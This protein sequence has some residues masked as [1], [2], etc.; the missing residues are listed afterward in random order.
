MFPHFINLLKTKVAFNLK[1]EAGKSQLSYAWWLLEPLLEA[2]VFYVVFGIFMARGTDD[3]VAFLLTGLIPFTWFSRSITNSMGSLRSATWALNNFRINPLFFPL[4]E[5]GQDAVKQIFTFSFLICFLFFY[6]VAPSG[7]WFFLPLLM[8]LQLLFVTSVACFVA[9]IIPLLEDLRYLVNTAVM[10]T[11]FASGVFFDPQSLITQ[12]WMDLFYTNP[13]AS[14][15][16]MYRDILL[17]EESPGAFHL[18]S[19]FLWTILFGLLSL[20]SM[21]KYRKQYAR[22]LLE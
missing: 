7:S 2:T 21:T 12:E 18:C 15:L 17:F 8:L 9:A 20:F 14:L 11:M 4:V 5:I 13:V 3:F 6:G 16:Q 1:A 22:L 10:A 19:V